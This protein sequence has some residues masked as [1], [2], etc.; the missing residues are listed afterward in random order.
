ML[1]TPSYLSIMAHAAKFTLYNI[2]H[3][4]LYED[5]SQDQND[6]L[7]YSGEEKPVS[8]SGRMSLFWDLTSSSGDPIPAGVYTYVIKV[9]DDNGDVGTYDPSRE[10]R[11][12]PIYGRNV[13]F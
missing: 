9:R 4:N 7:V 13:G 1:S 6:R 2:L 3:L 5:E 12:V 8:G 11:G 10:T